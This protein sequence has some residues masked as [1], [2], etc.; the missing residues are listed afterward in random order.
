ME[1]NKK[2]VMIGL[3]WILKVD[4]YLINQDNNFTYLCEDYRK[5]SIVRFCVEGKFLDEV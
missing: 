2:V 3:D 5:R 1:N 4:G